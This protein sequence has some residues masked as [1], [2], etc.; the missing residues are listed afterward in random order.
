M[1]EL[2]KNLDATNIAALIGAV[3]AVGAGLIAL[4]GVIATMFFTRKHRLGIEVKSKHRQDWINSLRADIA[5]ICSKAS[6]ITY[7]MRSILEIEHKQNPENK[8][9]FSEYI[10]LNSEIESASLRVDLFLNPNE[11]KHQKLNTYINTLKESLKNLIN[12]NLKPDSLM[13][14]DTVKTTRDTIDKT[15][16]SIISTSQ[17]IFKEEWIRI[18]KGK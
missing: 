4:I 1:E 17:E 15:I 3:G 10:I 13:N 11:E 9:T 2:I 6:F 8:R 14:R 12:E 16:K 5:L 7:D 18:K